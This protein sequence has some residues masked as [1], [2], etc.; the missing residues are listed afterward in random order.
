MKQTSLAM[1]VVLGLVGCQPDK[2]ILVWDKATPPTA[3]IQAPAGFV[4]SP[5]EA[6]ETVRQK[7][8]SLS[9]KHIWHIYADEK[10]YYIIDSFLG[11]N[12]KKAIKT[13]VIVDGQS[14]KIKERS[15]Q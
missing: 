10:N 11:S 7:P 3:E 12:P 2:M 4:V 6:Y 5:L 13:G 14:G 1:L 15:P 8:W 9:L